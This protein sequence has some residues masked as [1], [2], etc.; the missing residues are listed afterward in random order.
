MVV[1]E[2]THLVVKWRQYLV[3]VISSF[4]IASQRIQGPLDAILKEYKGNGK[5]DRE[6]IICVRV[7]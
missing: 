3:N 2:L 1:L 5:H 7:G 4:D 6:S